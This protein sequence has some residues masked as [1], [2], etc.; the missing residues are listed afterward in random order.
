MTRL[1]I[2]IQTQPISFQFLSTPRLSKQECLT[3]PQ[4]C[5]HLQELPFDRVHYIPLFSLHV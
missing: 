4:S 2:C 5:I 3:L 1:G